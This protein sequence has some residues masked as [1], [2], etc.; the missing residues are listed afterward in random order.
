LRV[1]IKFD[2][3]KKDQQLVAPLFVSKNQILSNP[4]EKPRYLSNSDD[5]FNQ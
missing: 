4:R 3:G 1:P 5:Y 2:F